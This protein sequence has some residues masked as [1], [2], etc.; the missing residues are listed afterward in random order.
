MTRRDALRLA[1]LIAWPAAALPH[2]DSH[3][4][5][6]R[7]R[8]GWPVMPFALTDQHGRPFTQAQLADRW[9]FVLFGDRGC[10]ARCDDALAALTGVQRRIARA[11]AVKSMQ[12]WVVWL[13]AAPLEPSERLRAWL[14]RDDPR[15]VATT[16]PQ[17][18]LAA[19]LDDLRTERGVPGPGTL[20]LIGPD[21][22]RRAEYPPPYDVPWLT[23]A[24]LKAR[25]GH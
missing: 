9:T 12:V 6:V 7:T 4:V 16:G 13:D 18:T 24:F 19:L 22:S 14:A 3:Q 2:D 8:A 5:V 1:G 10:Q 20:L 11:E 23:A 21:A 25:V 15:L 17:A